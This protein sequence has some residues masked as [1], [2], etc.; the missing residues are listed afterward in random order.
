MIERDGWYLVRTVGSHRQ[1]HHTTKS[2]T[3]T[4]IGNLGVENANGDIE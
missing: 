1:F 2:G 4:V 3:V